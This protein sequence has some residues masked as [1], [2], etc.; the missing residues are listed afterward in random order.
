MMGD[1]PHINFLGI[2][3]AHNPKE[4]CNDNAGKTNYERNINLWGRLRS[5]NYGAIRIK[6]KYDNK[7]EDSF[8]IPHITKQD[9]NKLADDY[10]QE[11]VIW[12]EKEIDK[13]NNPFYNFEYIKNGQIINKRIVSIGLM[14]YAHLNPTT[15][16][17]KK[18]ESFF[19]P[20]FDELNAEIE[21]S[22]NELK[23][24]T[25]YSD[26][27]PKDPYIL[28]L[29]EEIRQLEIEIKKSTGKGRWSAR[30]QIL[31]ILQKLAYNLCLSE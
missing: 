23:E 8:L 17:L 5:S 4:N 31:E 20:F 6:G 28:E 13:N 25:F 16:S 30:G 7:W 15:L 9:L 2:M 29:V 27:L 21:M 22:N 1:V 19:I 3:T 26:L 10:C 11:A 12:G 14:D 18:A 24:I